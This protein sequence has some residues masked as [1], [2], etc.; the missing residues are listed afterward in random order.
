VPECQS[1]SDCPIGLACSTPSTDG[2][3]SRCVML[4]G[5]SP[6]GCGNCPPAYFGCPEGMFDIAYCDPPACY[7]DADCVA[8]QTTC[9]DGKCYPGGP[10]RCVA[11]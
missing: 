9:I 8:N 7:S 6:W 2:G 3:I 4:A 1:N 5:H 10:G 11:P